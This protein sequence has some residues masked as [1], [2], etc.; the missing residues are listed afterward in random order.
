MM[1]QQTLDGLRKQAPAG[2]L[3]RAVELTTA[4]TSGAI[5]TNNPLTRVPKWENPLICHSMM[6]DEQVRAL[7]GAVRCEAIVR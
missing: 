6:G 7:Q 2:H 5:C 4:V 1:L 3:L